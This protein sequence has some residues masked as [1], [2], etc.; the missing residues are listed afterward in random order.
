MNLLFGSWESLD[1]MGNGF[2]TFLEGS[3]GLSCSRRGVLDP[4]RLGP[5][6]LDHLNVVL[7]PFL[8][9]VQSG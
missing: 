4:T 3:L 6:W 9:L 1:A 2:V 8:K 5:F 7:S